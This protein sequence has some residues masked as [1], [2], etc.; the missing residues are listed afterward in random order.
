M[1]SRQEYQLTHLGFAVFPAI[2][3]WAVAFVAVVVVRRTAFGSVLTGL[4][5]VAQF[6]EFDAV[7]EHVEDSRLR[8]SRNDV[9]CV[10]QEEKNCETNIIRPHGA[11]VFR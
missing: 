10:K 8:L 5:L 1:Y 2:S 3:E 6:F 4:Q 9:G 11:P 7:D